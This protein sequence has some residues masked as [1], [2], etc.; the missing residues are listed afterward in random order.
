MAAPVITT[1]LSPNPAS[2]NQAADGN[3]GVLAVATSL[4][5]GGTF[6][7]KVD[8]S[9]VADGDIVELRGYDQAN[10]ASSLVQSWYVS[11]A[12]AQSDP[13]PDLPITVATIGYKVTLKQTAGTDRTFQ[14][15]V[16]NLS[17]I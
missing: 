14:W 1:L 6:K 17:G 9:D 16:L 2:G 12:N 10:G 7:P 11:F 5:Q 4:S 13:A 3:E 15:S 8:L